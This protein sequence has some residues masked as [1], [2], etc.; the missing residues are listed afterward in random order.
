[1]S[2]FKDDSLAYHRAR[3]EF[4]T[5][6]KIGTKLTKPCSTQK[7]LSMAYSPGVAYA[8]LEIAKEQEEAYSYTNKGNLVAV[9]SDGS[10]VLGA[11]Q[12]ETQALY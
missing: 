1:M 8:S 2:E 7:E 10:A 11:Y 5:N 9:I 3:D 4:D 6:G 12:P